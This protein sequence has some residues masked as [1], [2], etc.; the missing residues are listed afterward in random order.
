VDIQ[1]RPFSRNDQEMRQISDLYNEV[2]KVKD[3]YYQFNFDDFKKLLFCNKSFKDDGAF[4]ALVNEKIVGF[5]C[6]YIRAGEEEDE[7]KPAYFNT[8]FVKP[9]Y[10][11]KYIGTKLYEEVEKWVKKNGKKRIRSVY[12]SPVNYPW[13][14]PETEHHNHP[15]APAIPVNTPEYF[16][17]IRHGFDI[18]GHIDA[19]HLPLSKYEMPERVIKNIEENKKEGLTVEVYDPVKHH[20]IE[21]FCKKIE[22]TQEGF[23]R[24]IR[25]NLN[26]EEPKPFLV[27]SYNGKVVGWTGPMYTEETGRGHLDGICVDPDIRGKGLGKM[28]FCTLCQYSKEHGSKF[29]TFFTGLENPARRIYLYAGFRVAQTF[30]IMCKEV[31]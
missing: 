30:A 20:G 14:I 16:F 13:Y 17:L 3:F 11:R 22:T 15:G 28:L 4:V 10:Q 18:Q 31:K 2:V 24:A 9:S 7:S 21:D 26:R 8:I 19:F 23:A 25:Y 27:G 6:G 12:L 5:A 29:M 1:I